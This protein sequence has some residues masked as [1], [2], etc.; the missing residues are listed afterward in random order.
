MATIQ[1]VKPF[2]LQLDPQMT[3]MPDPMDPDKMVTVMLPSEMQYFDIG[4]YDVADNVAAHWYVRAHLKGYQEPAKGP[5][6]A[7]F[8]LQQQVKP[9]EGPTDPTQPMPVN[10]TAPR[11]AA[12][13]PNV[14]RVEPVR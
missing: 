2:T 6:T 7:E 9:D 1:V 5:G 10:A 13:P 14:V 4:I 3:K 8:V 12:I 11:V